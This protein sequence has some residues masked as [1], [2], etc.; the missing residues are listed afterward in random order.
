MVTLFDPIPKYK[1]SFKVFFLIIPSFKRKEY[2]V[3][4]FSRVKVASGASGK[5]HM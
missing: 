1:N 2:D 5:Q 4:R 3:S